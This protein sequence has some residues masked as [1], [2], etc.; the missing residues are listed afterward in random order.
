MWIFY[1]VTVVVILLL[2]WK[3]EA[4]V[5]MLGGPQDVPREGQEFEV[6]IGIDT[7][8]ERINVV[9]VALPLPP[10][11]QLIGFNRASSAV[12]LWIQEPAYDEATHTVSFIG[13]VPGG[14]AG[15]V[16]LLT[17]RLRSIQDGRFALRPSADSK[18]YL[19]DGRGSEA[20]VR[21]E[22]LL[23]EV[24]DGITERL[25]KAGAWIL[26]ILT[27]IVSGMVTVKL[28]HKKKV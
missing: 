23:I 27:I 15:R 5:Y 1:R 7:E 24:D 8:G 18:A 21:A 12:N 13:G 4:A 17:M 9:D 20:S 11:F 26:G 19:N 22:E 14:V 16:V 28:W 3:G 10:A 25:R 6:K 2:P